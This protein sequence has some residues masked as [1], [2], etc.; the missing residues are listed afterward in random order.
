M[1]G[2]FGITTI[3]HKAC[4]VYVFGDVLSGAP[5][6]PYYFGSLQLRSFYI[7]EDQIIVPSS[8]F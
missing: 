5:H 8:A 1:L 3:T 4:I 7:F 2:H 6:T